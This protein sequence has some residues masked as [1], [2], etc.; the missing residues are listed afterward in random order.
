M[1]ALFADLRGMA[2]DA[3]RLFGTRI[4]RLFAYGFLSVIMALY[5]AQVGLS[6]AQIGLL[7]TLT[8]LGDTAVSLWITTSAD[9][10]GRRRMLIIG[11]L[12]MI[13]ASALFAV[14]RNFYLL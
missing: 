3:Y 12:L 1:A 2:P 6:E 7:L 9:R 14:T 5:L 13:F 4:I 11:A 10:I 8:L